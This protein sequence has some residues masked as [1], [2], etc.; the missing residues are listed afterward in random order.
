MRGKL[1]IL[2]TILVAFLLGT[3][4]MYVYNENKDDEIITVKNGNK[5]TTGVIKCSNDIKVDETGVST[6]VGE[7]YDATVTIQDYKNDKLIAS[8][9]G[10]VYKKDDKY[11]YILTNHHVISNAEKVIIGALLIIIFNNKFS[12]LHNVLYLIEIVS[13]SILSFSF[14]SLL[15]FFSSK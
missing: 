4:A 5:E 11:G 7:I 13:S 8:G 14:I 15:F 6:A 2:A 9:S 1:V 10:F 12:I 3:V